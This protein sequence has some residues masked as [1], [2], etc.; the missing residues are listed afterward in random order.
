MVC[1]V[2]YFLSKIIFWRAESFGMF[3][4]ERLLLSVVLAGLSGVDSGLL[5]LSCG[6]ENAQRVFG[7]YDALGTAGLLAASGVYSLWVGGDYRLAGFLTVCSYG[8]AAL[9]TLGLR[10]VKSPL[11]E[12]GA[13]VREFRA[14]GR[15]T[16]RDPRLLAFLLGTAAERDLPL[17][18]ALGG[19]LC[20]AGLGLYLCGVRGVPRNGQTESGLPFP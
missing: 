14:I 8:L 10:D 12:K 16:L 3:L 1:G 2:L 13:A 20:L 11:R 18:M 9:L 5:Y 17:A 6:P 19:G 7:W 15:D 4:L